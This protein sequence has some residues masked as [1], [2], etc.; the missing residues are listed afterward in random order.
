MIQTPR[1]GPGAQLATPGTECLP[2]S[3][4]SPQ[5]NLSHADTLPLLTPFTGHFFSKTFLVTRK[6]SLMRSASPSMA[7]YI[8]FS[9]K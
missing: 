2:C 8:P 7:L 9:G 1:L 5:W 6:S 4:E 3:L